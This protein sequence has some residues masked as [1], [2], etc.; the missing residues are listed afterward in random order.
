MRL[1]LNAFEVAAFV[2]GVV[3][4]VGLLL[5][6]YLPCIDDFFNCTLG[7]EAEDFDVT[8]LADSESPVLGL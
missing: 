1:T 3:A 2:G 5:F 8:A 4:D 7:D 6:V